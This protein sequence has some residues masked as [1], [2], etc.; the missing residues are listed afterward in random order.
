MEVIKIFLQTDKMIDGEVP[1]WLSVDLDA[2]TIVIPNLSKD[3]TETASLGVHK[4][5]LKRTGAP[6]NK[7][8]ALKSDKYVTSLTADGRYGHP[9]EDAHV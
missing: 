8:I 1:H 9:P 2:G 5:V 6:F 7:G 4:S 3:V